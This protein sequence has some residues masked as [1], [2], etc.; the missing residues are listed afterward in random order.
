[1]FDVLMLDIFIFRAMLE[2]RPYSL[3]RCQSTGNPVAF[4]FTDSR[5]SLNHQFVQPEHR[6]KGLGSAVEKHLC[7]QLI[8]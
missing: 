6:G 8:K 5:G 4:E 2:H 1:M 3:I 7:R